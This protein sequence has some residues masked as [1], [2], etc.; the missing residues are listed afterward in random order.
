MC[1][2]CNSLQLQISE[3]YKVFKVVIKLE[4]RR[5]ST[6]VVT[7]VSNYVA[8]HPKKLHCTIFQSR[9][10]KKLGTNFCL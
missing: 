1:H 9:N 4:I 8:R 2:Y 6:S 7:T 10:K 3:N 5:Q